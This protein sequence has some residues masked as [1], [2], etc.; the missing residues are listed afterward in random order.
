[1]V[2]HMGDGMD[3]GQC[4]LISW[5]CLFLT[6]RYAAQGQVAWS[7]LIDEFVG[8][9]SGVEIAAAVLMARRYGKSAK[10]PVLCQA[11]G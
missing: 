9:R 5:V 4:V 6:G 3:A 8:G 2:L 11:L 10:T 1:M 7:Q